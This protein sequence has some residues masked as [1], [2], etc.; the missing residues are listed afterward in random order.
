MT[1]TIELV[2]ITETETKLT[3]EPKV[4]KVTDANEERLF[5]ELLWGLKLLVTHEFN[6]LV[7]SLSQLA[8][9]EELLLLMGK[10]VRRYWQEQARVNNTQLEF[11]HE[12]QIGSFKVANPTPEISN[13]LQQIGLI[14][15][16][17]TVPTEP[18][19]LTTIADPTTFPHYTPV[20][21]TPTE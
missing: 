10:L 18:P 6:Q 14:D 11:G 1:D 8:F 9:S 5:H 2:R 3:L 21:L 20:Q 7:L 15:A 13:K 19:T 16:S 12:H 17:G 4:A